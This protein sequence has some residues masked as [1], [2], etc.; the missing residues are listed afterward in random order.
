MSEI[1]VRNTVSINVDIDP[2]T[3]RSFIECQV[4][5]TM[6]VRVYGDFEMEVFDGGPPVDVIISLPVDQFRRSFEALMAEMDARYG[7]R[8]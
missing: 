8:P 1:V 2:G 3:N 6:R 7:G 4:D 5:D